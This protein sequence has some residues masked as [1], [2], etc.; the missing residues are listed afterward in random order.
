MINKHFEVMKA[1]AEGVEV[2][3][4]DV[5]GDWVDWTSGCMPSF[6]SFLEWRIKPVGEES[7]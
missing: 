4:Q 6:W 1:W 7:V 5:D 3:A 2:Q